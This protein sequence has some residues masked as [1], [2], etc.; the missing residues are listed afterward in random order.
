[1]LIGWRDSYR[2]LLVLNWLKGKLVVSSGAEVVGGT[3]IGFFW[4]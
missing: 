3:A 1:V 4:C 2:F